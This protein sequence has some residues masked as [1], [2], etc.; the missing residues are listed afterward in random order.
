M[1]HCAPAH[2]T[3]LYTCV[4]Y[5]IV[6]VNIPLFSS[7]SRVLNDT[8]YPNMFIHN[9][10][11]CTRAQYSIVYLRSISHC[12]RQYLVVLV[13][14]SGFK[15]H[16]LSE[17]VHTQCPIVH[18]HTIPHCTPAFNIPWFSSIPRVLNDTCYPNMFIHNIPPVFN[19]TL[20]TIQLYLWAT[21]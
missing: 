7:I 9:V 18:P 5:P 13:N 16:M 6:L 10:S 11:L 19:V 4:Q 14:T 1:S 2:N 21:R 8:C 15:W 12:S 17:H 3:P 20:Y